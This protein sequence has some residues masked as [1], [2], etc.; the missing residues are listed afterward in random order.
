MDKRRRTMMVSMTG[1]RGRRMAMIKTAET[2][3]TEFA[4][5]V[6]L[7]YIVNVYKVQVTL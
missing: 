7:F 6:E 2:S 3:K 4:K 1:R 5:K